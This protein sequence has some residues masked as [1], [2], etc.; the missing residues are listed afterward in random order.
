MKFFSIA[1]IVIGVIFFFFYGI[2]KRVHN[3]YVMTQ[4]KITIESSQGN[5]ITA[6]VAHTD[7]ERK[8]GLSVVSELPD[9]QGMWFVFPEDDYHGIWMKDMQISIDILW[10]DENLEIIHREINISPETYPQIFSP[11]AKSR[12][13]LEVPANTADKHGLFLGSKV[14]IRE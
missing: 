6:F 2:T 7:N 3:P 10:L 4:E 13:V 8:K 1:G 11:S 5:T 14:I 9:N 12:F